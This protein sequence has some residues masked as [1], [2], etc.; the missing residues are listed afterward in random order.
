MPF[1]LPLD[2][3]S[4]LSRTP[5]SANRPRSMRR[6]LAVLAIAFAVVAAPNV[7]AFTADLLQ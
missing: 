2:E 3:S 7:I 6:K 1:E 4:A 5:V